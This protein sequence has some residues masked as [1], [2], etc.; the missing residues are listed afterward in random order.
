MNDSHG[1]LGW[2]WA[3]VLIA[4]AGAIGWVLM[5]QG[6]PEE[7]DLKKMPAPS[8]SISATPDVLEVNAIEDVNIDAELKEIDTSAQGL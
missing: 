3:I 1:S 2:L 8:S 4:L 7:A 6:T 5:Q